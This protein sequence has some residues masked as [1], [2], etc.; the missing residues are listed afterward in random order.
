MKCE[1]CGKEIPDDSLFCN[2]CGEDQGKRF[3]LKTS[4]R[5]M[6]TSVMVEEYWWIDNNENRDVPHEDWGKSRLSLT[7]Y[8]RDELRK[9]RNSDR[10]ELEFYYNLKTVNYIATDLEWLKLELSV[11]GDEV[12]SDWGNKYILKY[13]KDGFTYNVLHYDGRVKFID[14]P[15]KRCLKDDLIVFE[16]LID[17]SGYYDTIFRNASRKRITRISGEKQI[18][19]IP[20]DLC[21]YQK[22]IKASLISDDYHP[23][24][25]GHALTKELVDILRNEYNVNI[26]RDESIPKEFF[27]K[28]YLAEVQEAEYNDIFPGFW[29]TACPYSQNG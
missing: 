25:N 24:I 27:D 19:N 1:R 11:L 18:L 14:D 23:F 2:Y 4:T 7:Y 15:G 16:N 22:K 17:E 28:Y 5:I 26:Y 29:Y 13:S 9:F 10:I 6:P 8:Q 21:F 3:D 20:G 12:L